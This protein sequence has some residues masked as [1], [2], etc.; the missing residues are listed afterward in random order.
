MEFRQRL[1]LPRP[2]IQP[3]RNRGARMI[4]TMEI[5]AVPL[6][7]QFSKT[8]GTGMKLVNEWDGPDFL[9]KLGLDAE[10]AAAEK[11]ATLT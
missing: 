7:N 1:L 6:V 11:F 4:P 8:P 10:A 2:L 5:G 9:S 3:T